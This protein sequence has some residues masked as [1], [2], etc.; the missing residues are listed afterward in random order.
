LKLEYCDK[1]KCLQCAVGNYIVKW[2]DI[3]E[4][5]LL[6]KSIIYKFKMDYL[7]LNEKIKI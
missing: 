6:M 3:N 4:S 1:N 7:H 5:F 2:F